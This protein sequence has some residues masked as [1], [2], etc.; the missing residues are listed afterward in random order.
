MISFVSQSES[1][2]AAKTTTERAL[3]AIVTYIH[4]HQL[5]E[6]AALP[7]A[8][9]FCREFGFSRVIV[10]EALSY[11]KGMGIVESGRGSGCRLAE[12]RPLESFANLLPFFFGIAKDMHDIT[13]LRITMELGAFPQIAANVTPEDLAEM[14]Q[15]LDETDALLLQDDFRNNDFIQLDGNFHCLLAR[16]SRIRMLE[17]VAHAYF[18]EGVRWPD[19]NARV[20]SK[21]RDMYKSSNQEHHIICHSLESGTYDVGF[22]ALYHHL[23]VTR[24]T[25]NSAKRP[26]YS[27][28]SFL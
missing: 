20:Q 18:R 12:I 14:R 22:L 13:S 23:D 27:A 10:R 1:G 21:H 15:I 9:F 5:T 24:R 4:A 17:I 19:G 28:P 16:I 7:S 6:G 3:Q 11:L 26:S 25:M 2:N 8:D